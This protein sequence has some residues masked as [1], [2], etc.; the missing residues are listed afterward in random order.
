M[1]Q[2]IIPQPINKKPDIFD[3]GFEKSLTRPIK[4]IESTTVY[5]TAN[6]RMS[7]LIPAGQQVTNVLPGLLTEQ[8]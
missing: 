8:K 4:K 5:D 6:D 1:A 2:I 7:Q 3:Y